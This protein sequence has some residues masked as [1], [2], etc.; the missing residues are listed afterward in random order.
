M[1]SIGIMG[2]TFNP[3]HLGHIEIAKAAFVQYHLDEIWFLPNHIPGYKSNTQLVSG[4]HRLRMVEAAIEHIPQFKAKDYELNRKGK[5]YTIDTLRFLANKFDKDKFFFIMG[6][7]S[8]YSFPHWKDAE[9]ILHYAT[10]LV[11]PRGTAKQEDVLEK[12]HEMNIFY[13]GDYFRPIRC[14]D[15]PCSSSEI[16]EKLKQYRLA[17]ASLAI[18]TLCEKLYLPKPVCEYIMNNRIYT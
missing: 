11:A 8:L 6:A 1:A 10:M 7:D 13:T 4:M 12:M 3:I 18:Q 17:N 9:Q 5:T 14:L 15:I 16:R 2:G